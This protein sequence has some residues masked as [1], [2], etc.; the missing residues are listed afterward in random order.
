M[1]ARNVYVINKLGWDRRALQDVP[2]ALRD[3]NSTGG[4][5]YDFPENVRVAEEAAAQSL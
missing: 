4:R 2:S 1:T 3:Y 5:K